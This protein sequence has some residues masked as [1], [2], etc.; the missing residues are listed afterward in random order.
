M[1]IGIIGSSSISHKFCDA[2]NAQIK[3]G[4]DISLH[5]NYS[6]NIDTAIS[7]AKTHNIKLS[8]DNKLQM[9]ETVDLVYIATPNKL[10]YQDVKLALENN[11]HVLVEKPITT[12]A[13]QTRMLFS[14]AKERNLILVEAIKT[15]T[16]N[17][18]KHLSEHLQKIGKIKSFRLNVMR[19]YQNFP[20]PQETQ[21]A[22]IFRGDMEGGVIT[23]LGSYALF[24]LIDFIYKDQNPSEINLQAI[25][26]NKHLDVPCEAFIH[27]T[28]TS[29][30]ISGL[31]TLSMITEDNSMSYINGEFGY[32]TIDSLTQFNQIKY[33][34]LEH[35]LLQSVNRDDIHLMGTEL[36][37]TLD[38]I[39][40]NVKND[41]TDAKRSLSVAKL[42]ETLGS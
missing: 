10:H 41:N 19:E 40:G 27:T 24:P 13:E 38:L 14:L 18:Y 22:N 25:T 16:M 1:K 6:R 17:T 32:I 4:V 31:I 29:S 30:D 15:C 36:L 7:F 3:S 28:A 11:T 2:V 12:T 37:Y 42:I 26:Y 39:S 20:K 34:D 33:Y 5:A 23:D 35:N 9:L 8:L 21:I